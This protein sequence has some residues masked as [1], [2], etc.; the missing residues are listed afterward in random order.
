[1]SY[2][3]R[4]EDIIYNIETYVTNNI[5]TYTNGITTNKNDGITLDT[6]KEITVGDADPY[7]RDKYPSVLLNPVRMESTIETMGSDRI[8]IELAFIISF[9]GGKD[10]NLVIK[11]MRY[12]EAFR[13]LLL[14]DTTC[15]N[16]VDTLDNNMNIDYYPSLK[17]TLNKKVIVFTATFYKEINH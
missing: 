13:Q 6:F 9:T 4:L 17:G 2:E 3:S 5:N 8:T 14:G 11:A 16:A 10:A 15:G 12:A 1:M 7:N